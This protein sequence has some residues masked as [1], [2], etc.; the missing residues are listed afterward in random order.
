MNI[1]FFERV[2]HSFRYK[3]LLLVLLPLLVFIPVLVVFSLERTYSFAAAQLAHKVHTDINV[4]R[5]SFMRQQEKYLQAISRLAESHAFYLA[6]NREDVE[7]IKNQLQLLK[8][9]EGFDFVHVVDLK[10]GW[11]FDDSTFVGEAKPSP[12]IEDVVHS[13]VPRVG[14]ELYSSA[15][16]IREHAS[17]A[18]QARV[19]LANDGRAEANNIEQ[20]AMVVRAVYPIK[21]NRGQTIALMEGGVLLNHN[22]ALLKTIHSLVYGPGALPK[23]GKG[24]VSVVLDDVRVATNLSQKSQ[25]EVRTLGSHIPKAV[26]EQVIERGESWVGE[27]TI[28]GGLYLAGYQPLHDYR[29]NVIGM[30]EAGYLVA[31]LKQAYLRDMVMF[32][33]LLLLIV[34]FAT[35]F[36]ILGARRM[37]KPIERMADVVRAQEEGDDLRIGEIK[38]RDEIGA[39]ARRFDHMLDLLH[40]RNAEIQRAADNLEQQ[41]EERTRELKLKN[42][43]LKDSLELLRK[44]RSQLVMAEKFS[45]LGELTAGIAHEINNPTA[46]IL[47]NMDIVIEELNGATGPVATEVSLIYEQVYRIRNIV[48]K[49]LKYSRASPISLNLEDVDVKK[50]VEDTVMLVRHEAERKHAV[51]I[52]EPSA[53]N[54]LIRI[55][56]QELQQVLIN[57]LINAIHAVDKRGTIRISTQV[58]ENDDVMIRVADDGEGIDR[59]T[60]DRIFDPFYS[61]KGNVG[62]GLGL[63]VSYGLIHRYGGNLEVSSKPGKGTVFTVTLRRDPKLSPQVHALFDLHSYEFNRD[64]V[65]HE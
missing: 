40:E 22:S 52:T 65:R 50:L 42:T 39:L 26:H 32:G 15:Y 16:L 4:A 38:S 2:R 45:A 34:V 46:V 63:S 24:L 28:P 44:T 25:E 6:L 27:V 59:D 8:V 49:L 7:R 29:N 9:T 51:I 64:E 23:E 56:A 1:R 13:G 60:I 20:R 10:G 61:T 37:F 43:H 53:D 31:P 48:E 62:T 35:L 30:L 3:L 12:L 21:N 5:A 41:V 55:D 57:L 33:V 54:G 17:L 47:G 19:L 58:S 18:R 36:G 14:L 11:L